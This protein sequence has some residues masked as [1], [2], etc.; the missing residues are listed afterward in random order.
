MRIYHESKLAHAYLFQGVEYYVFEN[1]HK[2][3]KWKLHI[4]S[5]PLPDNLAAVDFPTK[6]AAREGIEKYI[7]ENLHDM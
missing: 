6:K 1:K 5:Q 4:P 3:G 7:S 2:S